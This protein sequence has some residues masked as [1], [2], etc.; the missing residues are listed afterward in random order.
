M[1]NFF[2]DREEEVSFLEKLYKSGE[3]QFV[4]V[5]GRRRVGKTTLLKKFHEG[6][7]SIFFVAEEFSEKKALETFS[8]Q[9]FSFFN[10]DDVLPPFASWEKAFRFITE[11]ARDKR[12][13]LVIDEFPYLV[14]ASKYL[15]SLLQN[16]IDNLFV[17]SQLFLI[18][19]GSMMSFMEKEVLSYKSPLYGRRTGQLLLLP[20]SFF[21][22]RK[23][24]PGY[25]FEDQLKVY[26][27]LGGIPQYLLAFDPGKGYYENVKEK[28]LNKMSFLY[29]EPKFLLRQE[30]REPAVYNSIIEA[31]A[32]G[33]SK[34]NEIAT[35]VG[36]ETAKCSTYLS[37]LIT[38]GIVEK[39]SPVDIYKNKRN[40]IYRLKD[41]FFRFWYRFVFPHTDMIEMDITDVLEENIIK[42]Q[43]NSYLGPVFEEVSIDY[44]KEL[45]KKGR[46]PFIF[47]KIGKWWGNNPVMKSEQEI[48]IIAY[49]GKNALFAECKWTDKKLDVD[50]Y[51]NL[52]EKSAIFEFQRK[53]YFL[54]SKNGFAT[55]LQNLARES[56]NVFLV[57]GK[58]MIE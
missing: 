5:Y 8:R 21:E 1:E 2:V 42:P 37:S 12:L 15:P 40:S 51:H 11:R 27:T 17:D 38:L 44:L 22:A 39:L 57:T 34:L 13:V 54:F 20:F 30:L 6:K 7:P 53:Y 49:D 36:M 31:I 25:S 33:N 45:N 52:V 19:S 10:M 48:D 24:F 58:D 46:L 41:H 50:T 23:F 28:I 43:M 29:E 55:G 26:A 32:T 16:L 9:I 14:S 56:G 47:Q 4:V 18:I 35:K 3:F